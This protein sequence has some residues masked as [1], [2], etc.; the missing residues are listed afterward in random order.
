MYCPGDG[1]SCGMLMPGDRSHSTA[2]RSGLRI[3][4]RLQQQRVDDAEDRGVGADADRER[5][6]DD[7]RQARA[8]AQ[9]AD[10]V[11]EVLEECRHGVW[12]ILV[13]GAFDDG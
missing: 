11:A 3:R 12:W 4:Q 13:T 9:R 5:R 1:Q 7:E 10:G 2:S 6:D 8:A